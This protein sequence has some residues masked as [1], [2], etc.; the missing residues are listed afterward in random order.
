M[1]NNKIKVGRENTV[2]IELYYQDFG[3]GRPVIHSYPRMATERK[4]MGKTNV[5][6]T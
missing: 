4:I 1:T 6:A 2:D 5:R 3:S